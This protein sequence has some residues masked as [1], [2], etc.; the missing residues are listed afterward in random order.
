MPVL[1][2]AG[3]S[4]RTFLARLGLGGLALATI[5]TSHALAASPLAELGLSGAPAVDL[6]RIPAP[7]QIYHEVRRMCQFGPRL[8][9]SSA[10]EGWIDQ[11]EAD[12]VELGLQPPADT[13][14]YRDSFPF[15]RWEAADWMLTVAGRPFP[16]AGYSPYSIDPSRPSTV[17]APMAYLGPVVLPSVSGDPVDLYTNTAALNIWRKQL[18]G[19]LESSAAGIPGGV[20]GKIALL[21]CPV[22]PL[23][24]NDF[25]PFVSYADPTLAAHVRDSDYKRV[26]TVGLFLPQMLQ[27]LA[28]QGA[29]GIV[30]ILDASPANAAGQY[31]P[32]GWPIL[33]PPALN[34]DRDTGE[35]LRALAE[36]TPPASITLVAKT[37]NQTSDCVLGVLPGNGTTDEVMILNTHTDGQNAFEENGGVALAMMARYFASQ[38]RAAR[39]RA[40]VF[41]LMTGHMAPGL[42]QAAN[43][44]ERHPDI[45]ASAAASV[46]VEHFGATEWLDDARGY[47]PTGSSEVCACFHADTDIWLP[48]VESVMD[49]KLKTTAA[50]RPIGKDIIGVGQQLY[51]A[52]VPSIS[53]IPGPNYLV[54]LAPGDHLDKLDSSL[55]RE[56]LIWLADIVQR[57]DKIPANILKTGDTTIWANDNG[58]LN[59]VP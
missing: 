8:T 17:Q 46:S 25:T 1:T 20:S 12:L 55:F 53:Y 44:V 37:F 23:N 32:Y 5:P 9:G 34:V 11:L 40:L 36:N 57:L 14:S 2:D 45:V 31:I 41:N 18:I 24:S 39:N 59:G 15:T 28:S 52:G 54:S 27:W 49:S 10:H 30:V 50:M 22:P 19:E 58:A 56:Q 26:W 42:P 16:V 7:R 47:H 13:G 21:D 35:T 51:D 6:S 43:L 29:A 48:T 3:V 33:G 38:P 4:R